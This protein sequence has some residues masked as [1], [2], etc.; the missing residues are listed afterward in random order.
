MAAITASTMQH[1]YGLSKVPRDYR[2]SFVVEVQSRPNMRYTD[3]AL[4]VHSRYT[5]GAL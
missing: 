4:E 5:W 3:G 2:G 1:V